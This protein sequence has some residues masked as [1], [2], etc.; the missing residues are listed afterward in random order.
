MI[1]PDH[2]LLAW[3]VVS[4]AMT[5]VLP[6]YKAFTWAFLGAMFFLPSNLEESF[7]IPGLPILAK[8][9][10]VT[11][12][13]LPATILFHWQHLRPRNWRDL[14]LI[15]MAGF[16]AYTSVVNG[17]SLYDG[18]STALSY[19]VQMVLIIYLMRVHLRTR[20]HA[21]YFLKSLFQL[22]ICYTAFL[23][24]E[25]RMSPQ[26]HTE[27]YGYF[28]HSFLQMARG[29]FYRP[30][31]FFGHGLEVA[32]LYAAV[33]L[34]GY[35]FLRNREPGITPVTVGFTVI[36][37]LST[38]SLGPI[39]FALFG[40]TLM[41]IHE[42][43]AVGPVVTLVPFGVLLVCLHCCGDRS[44]FSFI[45]EFFRKIS[46]DRAESLDYR[47]YAFELYITNIM[48]HPLFG[49]GTWSRGR[50]EGVATDSSLL[51]YLLAYGSAFTLCLYAWYHCQLTFLRR[52]LNDIRKKEKGI[53]HIGSALYWVFWLA[54][55]YN[56]IVEGTVLILVVMC[57][58]Y[59]G[60][61]RPVP[62]EAEA[63]C[64]G[65]SPV[66]EMLQNDAAG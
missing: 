33:V 22:S 16:A 59:V 63:P 7:Q 45:L 24:W 61:L 35:A 47:L 12:G 56:F 21:K 13:M 18:A 65:S 64:S 53:D 44:N 57:S 27:V 34:I 3:I 36:G 48:N 17:L 40:W 14:L 28:P 55:I 38:M 66:P 8:D 4:F 30:V 37:L 62:G 2:A 15:A 26:L 42:R 32:Y 58:A 10:V 25:W 29:N 11:Y 46:P 50:I 1:S 23:V 6:G 49:H 43:R 41:K 51:I 39:L 52:K 19:M 5:A 20:D 60:D 9:A 31:V 54:V